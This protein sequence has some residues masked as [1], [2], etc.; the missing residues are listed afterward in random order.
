MVRARSFGVC[1]R[2]A[3]LGGIVWPRC[4]RLDEGPWVRGGRGGVDDRAVQRRRTRSR[5]CGASRERSRHHAQHRAP[6]PPGE[7]G[8]LAGVARPAGATGR[9][10]R[11]RA[12]RGST[13][14]CSTSTTPPSP[15]RA[16]STCPGRRPRRSARSAGSTASSSWP[17]PRRAIPSGRTG[18]ST[19]G[20]S[21]TTAGELILTHYKTSPLF[22]VEHS[23]CP[24]DVYDWWI[25]RYG[26]T[27]DAFWP[28]V[29]TADRPARHH[30]G[31]R[32]LVPGERPRPGHERRRGR[33]PRLDPAPGRVER[34]LRDP[35]P[36]PRPG[37]Q[38]V[39]RSRP[40][41]APTTCPPT[42]RR[43][44]TRSAA[45]R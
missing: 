3:V 2:P 28:V 11:G 10:A 38:H 18:T 6:P 23:V 27:L 4:G 45:A 29:D 31:Q 32:G 17:R 12:C 30:D 43:P 34:L 42:R 33:L 41:W 21:S 40:T 35:E 7:G 24:H 15:R 16:R 5:P 39:R 22:P 44:S 9:V 36:G 37:Q 19:S 13:T 14:R 25:E 8:V 20:S 26:R 1:W